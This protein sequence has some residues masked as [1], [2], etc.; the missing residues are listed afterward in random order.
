MIERFY[1]MVDAAME[2]CFYVDTTKSLNQ[3]QKQILNWLLSETFEPEFFAAESF[4]N[5]H[6]NHS[7]DI[8]EI[9]P[10]LNFETAFSTNAVA[11]CHACGL[12]TVTRLERSRRY[13]LPPESNRQDFIAKHHD[14][15][16][17]CTYPTPL[18]TFDTGLKPKPVQTVPIISQGIEALRELNNELGLGMD[19]WD[20][21]FYY[22]L[23]S[24]YFHRDPTDV[25][26]FQLAQANSEHSRH[27]F[28]KGSLSINGARA[29]ETLFKMVHSTLDA[30]HNNS[31]IAFCDNSSAIR[32]NKISA[33]MPTTPG[34]PS[35]FINRDVDYDLLFT[36]ETHNFPSGV[37]P[38][39]GAQTGTGG[40]I[41]D[42][43][44]TGAGSL[45]LAATAGYGVGCLNLDDYEIP[46]EDACFEYSNNLAAPAQILIEESNGASDYG[47]KFGEPVI[48]GFVRSFGQRLPDGDRREWI[49]PIMFTGGVGQIDH[50][51]INKGKAEVG[52]RIVAVGGPAYRIG[53]GGGAA[54][55]MIQGENKEELDFSAVQRGDAQM[56]Q[57]LN[58]VIRACVEMGDDNPIISIHDQGA[59][60]P[61]NVIT[62]LMEPVGGRIEIRNIN[63]GDKSLSVLEIW[64]AEYQER[65]ALLLQPQH[66]QTFKDLC[67]REKVAC[68][69]LGEITGDGRVV[70]HD[71]LNNTT[72]V[73]LELGPILTNIPQKNFEI[74][75]K[76]SVL[77]PL[78]LPKDLTIAEALQNVFRLPA[79][80]SKGYLVRKVDRS[81]TGLI[82][83]QQC[84]GPRQLTVA[85]VAVI[86]QSFTN[87][88]GAAI[89]IGEQ[90]LKGLVS[91]AAGARMSVAEALTNIVWARI[92]KI[93]DIKA[94]VNWM[95]AAKLPG[96]GAALYDA[97]AALRDVM[98]NLG[99]AADGGKDSLS[100][101]ARVGNETVKAPGQ[102]VV[103]AYAMVPDI[104]CVVT[105]DIKLPG[106]SRLFLLD[107]A[108]GK[109]RLGGSAL[110]QVLSQVGINTP[111]VDDTTLLK[112]TFN[113]IQ[114]LLDQQLILAGHD[115]SDGGL[116]T[117]LAEMAMPCGCGLRIKLA[118]AQN[119]F[120][121]LF[122]EELG[123][124]IEVADE[125]IAEVFSYLQ[126]LHIPTIK[127]AHTTTNGR[128]VIE[129]DD[130][131]LL[132]EA[133]DT[134]LSWWE[135][136]S[137]RLEHL[138]TSAICAN[139]L[140]KTHN[141]RG[142]TYKITY[143]VQST[144]T[145]HLQS[146]NKPRVAILREEGTNGDREMAAA[147]TLAGF[148]TWDVA[149]SDLLAQ[150][151]H[152]DAF[153]GIAFPG[154]FSYADVLDSAKGWAGIIL[155]HSDLAQMFADFRERPDTFS[156][157]VCN[158]AQL[159]ALLGWV[160]ATGVSNDLQP[161]FIHNLSGRLESRWVT[162]S[163]N[164]SSAVMLR[165]MQGS[166]LG[167]WVNH[168]EGRLHC[169]SQDILDDIIK[170]RL[171]PV[172]YVDDEGEVTQQYPFNPNGSQ[173][174]I[175][176]LC[177]IDG[178]HLAMMPH[179]ERCFLS[180][181][182]PYRPTSLQINENVSPWL[183]IFQNAWHWCHEG[184]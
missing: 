72:P 50:R 22:R 77:Y 165:D 60:G 91:P 29:P 15:M 84:C 123:L 23:F 19:D 132:D 173:L 155:H 54:S 153:R 16:T 97:V 44:A 85:D 36:A 151:I 57:K 53:I 138:Q 12:D 143:K 8:V 175:A 87:K 149:M 172:F 71:N 83:Q 152:L 89:A 109:R 86:A 88:T 51:H 145:K 56:E 70:V 2:Y 108:C 32:G 147:F 41:R 164:E 34:A 170:R 101:A 140:P 180:W 13:L 40:R 4:F 148:E 33:L 7:Q 176:G 110:A 14:R 90:P 76:P 133:T 99:I 182:M 38:F 92:S 166:K 37:A 163:I 119:P 114:Q 9:G 105:P 46:G 3:E 75:R 128:I 141:R 142:P 43:H 93:E 25:E 47:N 100:M 21:N 80:G 156:L 126:G 162:V 154:G 167:V 120:A 27:W 58:R 20:I 104:S 61:C 136:T 49:K 150:R 183:K 65:S 103:S 30:H 169:R 107:I 1:R 161:R 73:N 184:N 135:A 144:L 31:V 18:V 96:E 94:S 24:E 28:F 134:L 81:V 55:S 79:V 127:I 116:I 178:R 111:D 63:I 26:C 66:L 131:V 78:K 146:N 10:R 45:V 59:G 121:T 117:T 159:S 98:V 129:N 174:G 112:R 158:G 39:P 69:D 95:W 124:V 168:G 48:Q 67:I 177:S 181:Q 113:A 5:N 115:I 17:E 52:M 125:N 42:G 6:N 118:D 179:P 160:P 171:V 157:G 64:G 106:N 68:E 82:V 35:P 74:T 122:A 130:I 139:E 102:V 62:E 137:D 11:I